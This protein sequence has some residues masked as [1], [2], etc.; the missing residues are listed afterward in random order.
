MVD[1]QPDG[2][3]RFQSAVAPRTHRSGPHP[4]GAWGA[5]RQGKRQAQSD[6]ARFPESRRSASAHH[7]SCRRSRGAGIGDTDLPR[8]AHMWRRPRSTGAIPADVAPRLRARQCLATT[9]EWKRF[10]DDLAEAKRIAKTAAGRT[11]AQRER[12]S[13]LVTPRQ[14]IEVSTA[15]GVQ[16]KAGRGVQKKRPRCTPRLMTDPPGWECPAQEGCEVATTVMPPTLPVVSEKFEHFCYCG[17]WASFGVGA[18][19]LRDKPG[20]WYCGEHRP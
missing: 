12:E 14:N 20:R 13:M 19:L 4:H 9:N 16:K 17:R 1:F 6:V 18:S 10:G 11:M 15:R 2:Q 3:R 7:G 5:R 8:A